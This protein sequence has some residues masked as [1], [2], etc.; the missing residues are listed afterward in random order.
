MLGSY[1]QNIFPPKKGKG[2]SISQVNKRPS[3]LWMAILI[4]PLSICV[5]PLLV[6]CLVIHLVWSK[7]PTS[8]LTI[9]WQCLLNTTQIS[10]KWLVAFC[11][12]YNEILYQINTVLCLINIKINVGCRERHALSHKSNHEHSA[13]K[14]MWLCSFSSLSCIHVHEP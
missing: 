2:I 3:H 1:L 9:I 4:N 13:F 12:W 8:Y 10:K 11:S 7:K 6:N 5:M 14:T